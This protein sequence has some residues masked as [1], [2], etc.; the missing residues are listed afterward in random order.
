[1]D[2][3]S[4]K[5]FGVWES[6]GID[7][8]QNYWWY[9]FSASHTQLTKIYNV[10]LINPDDIPTRMFRG[11]T[12]LVPKKTDIKNPA[13]YRPIT[14]LPIVYKI[15]SSIF[16]S[17]MMGHL[18][19]NNPIAEEQKVGIA[20]CYGCIDQL[21]INSIVLDDA[22]QRNKNISIAWIDYKKA[23]LSLMIG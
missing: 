14:C 2:N 19:T 7:S 17:R 9:K 1:M 23:I 15:L 4:E 20:D 21:L 18:K 5:C 22:K 10:M 3:R 11:I 8:L 16:A 13:N 6:P 12:K